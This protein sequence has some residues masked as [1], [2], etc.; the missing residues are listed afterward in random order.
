MKINYYNTPS[1]SSRLNF[2][3][4]YIVNIARTWYLF[5]VRYS[6]VKYKGFVRVMAHTKFAKRNIE[7]GNNVQF[8]KYCSI[9]SDLLVGNNVLFAARVCFVD[10]NDHRIDIPCKTIWESPR[11]ER[12]SIVIEDDVWIGNNC[13]VL[14]GVTVSKGAVVAAGAVVTK[15]IPACEV[16]GGVPARK[17][18]DRFKNNEE[19][20]IHLDYLLSSK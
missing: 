9:A 11:G 14:G 16:W 18:K 6:W 15:N 1:G 13:T 3:I 19:K 8:G 10:G 7:L 2:A 4:R 12:K 17:I 20:R 5:N